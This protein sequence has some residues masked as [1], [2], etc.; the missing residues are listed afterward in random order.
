MAGPHM[1]LDGDRL[2][3]GLV[4]IAGPVQRKEA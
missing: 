3:H 4:E 2:F 1:V